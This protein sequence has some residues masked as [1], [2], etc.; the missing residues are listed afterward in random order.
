MSAT[1]KY[2]AVQNTTASNERLMISLFDTALRHM[3]LSIQ[4]L[5]SKNP[6]AARPLLDKASKIVS[7]LHGTLNRDAAPRLVD[8]LAE[9]YVFTIARLSRA[10]ITGKASD[11]REAERTFAPIVEGFSH[12]VATVAKQQTAAPRP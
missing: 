6:S 1:H 3:R 7:Y 10:I 4:H 2:I 11:V 5:D 9:L 12:A 8:N